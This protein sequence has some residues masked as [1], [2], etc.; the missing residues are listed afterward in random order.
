MIA[1]YLLL[2]EDGDI[3]N[4]INSCWSSVKKLFNRVIFA[5]TITEMETA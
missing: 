1:Q 4:E 2:E 5:P 3:R